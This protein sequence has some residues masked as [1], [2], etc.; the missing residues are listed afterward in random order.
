MSVE[1]RTAIAEALSTVD[2]VEGYPKRPSVPRTGDGWALWGGA[3]RWEGGPFVTTWR[4]VIVLPSDEAAAD[5][6][7]AEHLDDLIDA[8]Q[9][10]SHIDRIDPALEKVAGNDA[11]RLQFTARE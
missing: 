2:G 8:L 3:E 7:V 5:E 9:R 11:F 6:W 4:I 1:T 10:V